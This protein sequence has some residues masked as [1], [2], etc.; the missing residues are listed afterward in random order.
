MISIII[1]VRYRPDLIR[2][3]IDSVINYTKPD[4]ELI[5]VQEGENKEITKL[6]RSYKTKFIQNKVPRGFAAANNA[7]LALAEGDYYCFLNSD[8]VV[9]PGWLESMQKV[10]DD[11]EVGLVV[12][13]FTESAT[14]QNVDY[15]QGQD[16]EYVSD[17]LVLKGVCFLLSKE[18]MNK[19]G[20]W[21]ESFGLGGGEDN[22][23]CIRIKNVGYKLAIARKAYI[24]HY[25]SASFRELFKNDIGRSRKFATHQFKKVQ[26][27]HN[28]KDRPSVFISIPT[29][30]GDIYHKLALRLIEWSHDPT[31]KIKIQFYPHLSPLDNA[32]NKAVKDFLEDYHDYFLHIDDDIIPPPNALQEL[33]KADKDVIAP[34]CFTTKTGDDGI[35]FP[36]PVAYRYNDRMEYKPYIPKT[37]PSGIHE[38]DIVT[39]GCHLVKRWVFEKLERPYYFT[40]HKNGVVIYSE[41]FV[42]SQQC[43]KKLKIKLYTHYG[44]RCGHIRKV[45]VRSINDLMAKYGR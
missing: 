4:Y 1:P 19:I 17:P 38:T 11:K 15:N 25:G 39:G 18:C 42:F 26:E 36:Q 29:A 35:V 28:F 24:Y 13:T 5:L 22:D 37:D 27:K 45:D 3:C 12:P 23:L 7:G 16:I 30:S 6:L 9:T 21:D 41:D 33:I 32:R 10:F 34:L 40:Y 20:K 8:V 31:L 43:K 44:L 2:V 14:R